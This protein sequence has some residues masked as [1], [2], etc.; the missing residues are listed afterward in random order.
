MYARAQAERGIDFQVEW[1][2][3]K[4]SS[5][6]RHDTLQ[7]ALWTSNCKARQNDMGHIYETER[8]VNGLYT[9]FYWRS[10]RFNAVERPPCIRRWI[11]KKNKYKMKKEKLLQYLCRFRK[12]EI[13]IVDAYNSILDLFGENKNRLA[14]EVRATEDF[15]GI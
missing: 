15:D 4:G 13:D 8:W 5:D 12:G 6:I 14:N 1:E 9:M 3:D 2:S 11:V 7:A 10:E